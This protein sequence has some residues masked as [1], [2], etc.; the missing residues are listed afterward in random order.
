MNPTPDTPRPPLTFRKLVR[1][2]LTG[3]NGNDADPARVY[4]MIAVFTFI[5]LAIYAV[6][7]KN[8]AW[9]A[10]SFG[11][12]FGLLLTGFGLGVKFKSHTEEGQ[13]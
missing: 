9:D 12:G 7:W 11:A 8:A 2:C 3:V 1:D 6:V 13:A 10:Q 5:G 4:G